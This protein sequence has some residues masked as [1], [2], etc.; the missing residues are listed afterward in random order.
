MRQEH[1]TDRIFRIA[2]RTELGD[3]FGYGSLNVFI[4]GKLLAQQDEIIFKT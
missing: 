4:A 2:K 3:D 1:E